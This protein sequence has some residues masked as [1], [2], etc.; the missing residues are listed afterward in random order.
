[1]ISKVTSA[2]VLT[3][4]EKQVNKIVDSVFSNLTHGR[5]PKNKRTYYATAED[6]VDIFVRESKVGKEAKVTLHNGVFNDKYFANFIVSKDIKGKG[7]IIPEDE[8]MTLR[9]AIKILSR[10]FK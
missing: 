8:K 1:M 7:E 5:L 10:Y 9:K 4:N 3:A 2:N 6:H